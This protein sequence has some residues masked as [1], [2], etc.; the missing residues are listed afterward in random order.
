MS[1][2]FSRVEITISTRENPKFRDNLI[3]LGITKMSAGSSTIVGGH[4]LG[5]G[6]QQFDILDFR[7]VKE[8]R[9][10]INNYGYHSILKDWQ[11]I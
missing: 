7:D 1:F 10:V 6:V 9:K 4:T 8:I 3:R 2:I 5:K 11:K